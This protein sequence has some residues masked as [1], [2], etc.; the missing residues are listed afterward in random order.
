MSKISRF[1]SS[2]TGPRQQ[3]ATKYA[4]DLPKQ[5]VC[6]QLRWRAQLIDLFARLVIAPPNFH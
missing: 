1:A 4:V 2:G 5:P 3:L 6:L